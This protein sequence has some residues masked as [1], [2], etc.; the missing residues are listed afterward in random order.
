[1]PWP[2][3]ATVSGDDD[4][5]R[6]DQ[7]MGDGLPVDARTL[8]RDHRTVL[9][10]EPITKGKQLGVGSPTFPHVRRALAVLA[11]TAHTCRQSGLMHVETTTPRVNHL[12]RGVLL[13]QMTM[14][15]GQMTG[16]R[17]QVGYAHA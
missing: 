6:C 10:P 4:L 15:G 12:H 17:L 16:R 3:N 1:M 9:G 8:H 2:V 13:H 11:D 14:T 7:D 5:K